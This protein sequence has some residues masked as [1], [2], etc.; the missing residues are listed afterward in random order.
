MASNFLKRKAEERAKINDK[1]YGK[2]TYGSTADLE[3]KVKASRNDSL[4]DESSST[5]S[6]G[7]D[8]AKSKGKASSFLRNK[9]VERSLID[10]RQPYKA[11]T[12]SHKYE[13]KT[14]TDFNTQS[15]NAY[16]SARQTANS[17]T[18]ISSN[19]SEKERK[20]RI[21]EIDSELRNLNYTLRGLAGAGSGYGVDA[22]WQKNKSEETRKRIAE[23][24]EEKTSLERVDKIRKSRIKE[25]DDELKQ[26]NATIE[27]LSRSGLINDQVKSEMNKASSRRTA[28]T[29]EKKALEGSNT[30]SATASELKQFEIED[31]KKKKAALP[32]FNPTARVMPS[33][34]NA[35]IENAKAHT[36]ADKGIELLERQKGLYD[37][38]SDFGDVVNKDNFDGQWRA[39]FRNSD[40]SR[41][42]DKAFNE[43]LN[44]P[45]D[46]KL[47]IAYDYDAF[48]K[49]Y[50]KNNEKAL[51]DEGAVA[52]WL[53]KDLA[54]YLP[55]L[56][57]QAP[58]ELLGG[59]VGGAL[60]GQTGWAIGSGLGSYSVMYDVTR[61]SVYRTLLAQGVDEETALQAAEDEALISSLIEGG[62]T[63]LGW[64]IG[65]GN[66]AWKAVGTAAKTSVAKGSTNAAVK[67]VANMAGK[68]TNRAAEKAASAV[69]RPLWNKA[70]RVGG[71]LV[72]G[73]LSEYG[74]EFT[75]GA[76]SVAN[77]EQA[78]ATV[79]EELGEYGAGNIN[80]HNRP[81]YKN[82]DGSISTV[83]SVLYQ[84][85]DKFVLLPTIAR[86]E[87]GKAI[88]LETDEE[89]LAH[90]RDTGEFL[91]EF[92]SQE[93]ANAYATKLHTAQAYRYGDKI[94]NADDNLWSGG[95]K[96][97]KSALSGDNPE[98]FGELHEQGKTG[99]TIGLM[100][101]GTSTTVNTIITNYANAKTV[102]L[103]EG[104]VDT[105]ANDDESL[106]ALI[107]EGK[108]SGEGTVS[109][110]IAKEI[111]TARAEGK[112]VTRNQI[113][114]LIESNDVYIREEE[115]AASKER[116]A[117]STTGQTPN[118]ATIQLDI[119]KRNNEDVTVDDVRVATGFGKSG[120]ELVLDYASM[121]G[122]SFSEVENKVKDS[123]FI[124]FTEPDTD[125]SEVE[126][127]NDEN[128]ASVQKEAF[129]AGQLDRKMQNV[130]RETKSQNAKIYDGTFTENEHTK[131]FTNV[132]KRL[133]STVA[134]N[135]GMDISTVDKI[136][137]E[138]DVGGRKV[139]REANASHDDGAMQ[140]S[141]NADKAVFK[142]IL[143]EGG[144]RMSELAP[145]EFGALVTELYNYSRG[146]NAKDG[147]AETSG[148]DTVIR[149]YAGLGLDTFDY[150]EEFGVTQIESIFGSAHSYNRWI[151][152]ISSNPDARTAW[153]K[154]VDYIFSVIDDIK[155]ALSQAKMSK[156]ERAEANARIDRIKEL[157]ANA[158]RASERVVAEKRQNAETK[159]NT[160]TGN[161][162]QF[163]LKNNNKSLLTFESGSDKINYRADN[164]DFIFSRKP[165][166]E[167][168]KVA[169]LQDI[170]SNNPQIQA[171]I[172]Q[173]DRYTEE[174]DTSLINTDERNEFRLYKAKEYY[175]VFGAKNKDRKAVI[176]IGPPAAGKS[177]ISNQFQ[178]ELGAII[179]DSDIVKE[180]D[181]KAGF[182]GIPEYN[183][184][185]G[186]S[187][188][189]A[190]SG[191]IT[192]EVL[193]EYILPNGDN[194]IIPKL[195]SS[196]NS[197]IEIIQK[198][199]DNEYE[200]TLVLNDLP[201]EKALQRSISR[202]NMTGRLVRPEIIL[203]CGYNPV[204]TYKEIKEKE[205]CD[206]Y[207]VYSNDVN[208]GEQPIL[209]ERKQT[210][211]G[212]DS[213]TNSFWNET[214]SRMDG[215]RGR[216]KL[217]NGESKEGNGRVQEEASGEVSLT[218]DD[219]Q[220][221]TSIEKKFSLK[222]KAP[223]FYSQMGKT[224]DDMKQDKIGANSVVS[225]LKGRGVKDEEIKWSGIETFLEGKKSVTKAELQEFAAGSML[226]IETKELSSDFTIEYTEDESKSLDEISEAI[227]EKWD[228]MESLWENKYGEEMPFQ[229]KSMLDSKKFEN[230]GKAFS[231]KGTSNLN[232]K[233]RKQLIEIIEH[234]KGEFEI[235]KFAKA[236]PKKL[237]KMTKEVLKDY[238]S[239]TDFDETFK[240]I[241][242][243]YLYMANGE[244]GH[245]AVWEDVYSRAY[246]IAQDII[247]NAL[248]L[249]DSMYNE[250]KHL[251]DYL[252]NTPMRFDSEYD[253]SPIAYEN[254]ND[255]RKHNFGR[256]K[257]TKDGLPIDTVYQEL[258]GLYPEFFNEERDSN[259][260]DQLERIIDVFD[261]IQPTEINPFDGHI[262][263][264]STDLANDIISRF[265][266]IPQA[267]PTF[268]DKA[269]RRVVDAK[270][271][272]ANKV[273]AVRQQRDD[274]IKKLIATQ[275]E[276]TKKQIDKARQQRDARVKKE[277]EK[278]REAIAKMGEKQK[279][280]V[281]RAQ[282]ERHASDLS[283]KL[284]SP[285]DNQHIPHELRGAVAT[286]LECINLESNYT[287]DPESHSYKKND[288][289]LPTRRTQAFNELKK[290]YG[291]IASSAVVDPDLLGDNGW[292]S[293]VI[294]L[295]DK[296]IVDMNSSEL[297]TVWQTIRAIE[298]SISASN[299]TFSQGKFE[300]ISGYAESL[301]EDNSGKKEKT[302]LKGVFGKGKTLTTLN[303]LTPET[304][305]HMLGGAGDSIFR[306]LRDAQDKHISIMKEVADFTRKTTKGIDVNSLEKTMH[307]V[308]L[309]GED[310]KLTTAQLMELYVLMKRE[311]AVEHILVGGILPDVTEGKG[312]KL[313]TR[314]EPVRNISM[315]EVTTALEN[316]TDE[317]KK[318]ADELQKFVSTVLSDYGNEAS[319]KVYNYEKFLEKNYW[320]IRTNKQEIVSEV[321]KETAVTSVANKGMAKGT[322]PHAN[323]SVRIGSI[324]DTFA[325]HSSDMATYAAWLG[326]SEDVNRIRN[327]VFWE[328]GV[329]KG[330]VKGIL[331]KVHGTHG[332]DYLQ[333]LLTDIA[334]GVQGTDNMNPFDQFIGSYKAAS[335]GANLRVVIQQPTAI[336]RALDMI[337]AR[338]LTEGAVHPLKGWEKAK[339]Y[340]PIA[341]WKDWGHFDINTGRQMK[342]VLFDN[343]SRLE[344]TKQAGMWGASMADSLA[345]GQ[346]WNAVEAE[347]KAKHKELA[348]GT[349]EYYETVAKRFTE[350]IDHTQVVDGILQRSQIMRSPDALTKMATSFMG[351]P[352]KQY[353]MAVASAYDF[354]T[355]KG[356]VR[357]K[358]ASRLGRTAVALAVAGMVN[359]V[360]QSIIDAMRDDDKEKDYWEKWLKA[361][362]GY[363]EDTKF[364]ESNLAGTVNP[365]N[366]IPFAKDIVSIFDG[367]DVK[368]MDTEAIT[369]TINAATNMYKSV[370]GEGKYTI[371]EASAQLFAEIGRLYGLPVAN[372]KRD[373][374]S[375]VTMVA[376][377]SD[378]YL[379][380]YRMEKVMLDINYSGNRKNYMDILFNAYNN[381]R[382]AYEYIYYDL[383]E[384]GYD[385]KTIKD[386]METRMK[387]AEGVKEASNLSKRYMTPNVE[388]KYDRGIKEIKSSQAWKSATLEQ[389]KEAK[390]GLYDFLTSKDE[391]IVKTREEA[392]AAGVDET[393]Y[394]LW[395][396]AIEMADQPKGEK[397]HG[398]YDYT[399]KAEAINSLELGDSEIAYFFGKGL[400]GSAK[401][402][403]DEVI[404][405]GIDIQEYV[406]FKAATSTM[407]ADKNANGKSIP[408]SKKRKVVNYLNNADLTDE[409]WR[410]FYYEIMNYKK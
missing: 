30:F 300:T 21:K 44:N 312:A 249:D 220:S 4:S 387:K 1:E 58:A 62:G 51:D 368:R 163:S 396:L 134:R 222:T 113:K 82:E 101:G 331:D 115:K 184:G 112:E 296:R 209:I 309:G 97:V 11:S 394:A 302:E 253:S 155:R 188:V 405:D 150:F 70:L 388:K 77:R 145:N 8:S 328:D 116:T 181:E 307:T 383:I 110:K 377:E 317:Q 185:I 123:Y 285:T 65:G 61:G 378:S 50:A 323:T 215:R 48:A 94:V 120:A 343:A 338:Y 271:K 129:I 14:T 128:V 334:I 186:V 29:E 310:V 121:E 53:T 60:F 324:F 171:T 64:L 372:V 201:I 289:G 329:R 180:G 304:Y 260:A 78:Y 143:H 373:V 102:E 315:A 98:L 280:K 219:S 149:D 54:G 194:V 12:T 381:D 335:V 57:D 20:A 240:A 244:N 267:K 93:E 3:K 108:A 369:K 157:Y 294:S 130:M 25:I 279:A 404:N 273:E 166:S 22:N 212:E 179:L 41:E 382:E 301:R 211:A 284:I 306:M 356:D 195:G 403:L 325:S 176:V 24:E 248:V 389:K 34:V 247:E 218:E 160:E 213:G 136:L 251:R 365:L 159:A 357:K 118:I 250:Y 141:S 164:A 292:L 147:N 235:T 156:A 56:R 193:R 409:E 231:L 239:Q 313:N 86:D 144:H 114:Q 375:L 9:A 395:Q 225:Y 206:G 47:Q 6:G 256:L 38:I 69:T 137:V 204:E 37:D 168:E 172:E 340:A 162:A 26:V 384:N 245:P 358:A 233:N 177:T 73:G 354:M 311:Q 158:Y 230:T 342:D 67:F 361:F 242:E 291:E 106:T 336:L 272:G 319:M 151:A 288:E 257:F 16:E 79:D 349:E 92:D 42:A 89:I 380:Q 262:S 308:K 27:G 318:V 99:F 84:I 402:E 175:D 406:N 295:A 205:L 397:G 75:Q 362:V 363:G 85:D 214:G 174:H 353:N 346:L 347:T 124:G 32:N 91:G 326:T 105:I 293:D 232:T 196:A 199:R 74:E 198:L 392:K 351:E 210:N 408:N 190:E 390:D 122:R 399:E 305:F 126:F 246:E 234:L 165:L 45:T 374:K 314:A 170:Y 320:T 173:I 39:N 49:A 243:L 187:A 217:G 216:N 241:D 31:A 266:D 10:A 364:T 146:E 135:L 237:T 263:Q 197:M 138:T 281:Y 132:E 83:D 337:D 7:A 18:T 410:Y 59:V 227:N 119:R 88:R 236:D 2:G 258:A 330:T 367:Y 207:E 35:H 270:I 344:K 345:W 191:Q 238:S 264:A 261:S 321:G 133:V 400:Y 55:Q 96:V 371:A 333:K 148:I 277:Q 36:E 393:E 366:Y 255:F 90:F 316:L 268:A 182:K 224:I 287:Y 226:Q 339:K 153:Q 76:V 183:N 322:K 283:K 72:G 63:A 332:S 139:M 274:K 252:R 360:A 19:L 87:N 13:S 109:E 350:I 140:I 348:V 298:A 286:L 15:K 43:Y 192:D 359:A 107:E 142:I 254:Y 117:P 103:R 46:E 178:K 278:R 161:D 80:L 28:L 202:Y 379:M 297:H 111:E 275:R 223:T 17:K 299:K 282:I 125:V 131:N 276:K 303:M 269:E 95:A 407:K 290:V 386:G 391:N 152:Q 229:E 40:L 355:G 208:F 401:E 376:I 81:T 71:R 5:K 385:E 23:L 370:T 100:M 189:H 52:S 352:T 169:M 167:S 203:K 398:S 341:Q 259:T 221:P 127:A 68:A 228:E 154:I 200:V 327:F 66:M 33:G 104:I 265:F